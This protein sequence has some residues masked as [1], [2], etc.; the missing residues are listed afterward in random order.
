MLR[1][2]ILLSYAAGVIYQGAR[3]FLSTFPISAVSITFGILAVLILFKPKWTAIFRMCFVV[4]LVPGLLVGALNA[5]AARTP[6]DFPWAFGVIN[7]ILPALALAVV[8][9]PKK[10][11]AE[12]EHTITK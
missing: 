5:L 11:K 9:T 3:E 6:S 8:S 2:L 4:H 12:P 10:S 7:M 1:T